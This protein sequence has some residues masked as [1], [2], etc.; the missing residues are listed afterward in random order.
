MEFVGLLAGA[1]IEPDVQ[2]DP[3]GHSGE[4]NND[5]KLIL[6]QLNFQY[7]QIISIDDVSP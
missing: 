7:I 2:F 1:G 4:G 6:N 5:N 3:G